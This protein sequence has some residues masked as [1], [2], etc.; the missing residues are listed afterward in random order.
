MGWRLGPLLLLCLP[1]L[2]GC[3]EPAAERASA[4]FE[5]VP[6]ETVS[7]RQPQSTSPMDSAKIDRFKQRIGFDAA[8][9][10][11]PAESVAVAWPD[12]RMAPG[13]DLAQWS[14]AGDTTYPTSGGV[15]REWV[16]RQGPRQLSIAV[17]VSSV[18]AEPAR[19]FLLARATENMLV[20]A[21]YVR[22]PDGP[23]TLA[24]TLPEP[25]PTDLIWVFRNVAIQ[26]RDDD[27]GVD[28]PAIARW[29]Q[30]TAERG[31]KPYPSVRARLPGPLAATPARA[32]V[33]EPIAVRLRI[34]DP[35]VASRWM[36]RLDD[37]RQAINVSALDRLGA[38]IEGLAPG[39]LVLGV[40]AIDS[41]TLLSV[42]RD[43]PL[44][45]TAAAGRP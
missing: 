36:I 31:I 4:P 19:Q 2:A 30:G 37:D 35:V 43:V 16:L 1:A 28:V 20:D 9:V 33:G 3:A 25:V 7:P 41:S 32:V 5:P 26:V 39:R 17:F 8:F 21:P 11:E 38:T 29:L 12:P 27:A 6:A 14:L 45:I 15:L 40:L 44:E 22:L 10:G 42:R 24:V 13:I 23:G 34:D 18:G